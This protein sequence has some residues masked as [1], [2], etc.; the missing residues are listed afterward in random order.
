MRHP[1]RL[2][3]YADR[4]VALDTPSSTL[5]LALAAYAL[6]SVVAVTAY[7]MDKRRAGTGAWRIS[8]A[9]LHGIELLGGWPG[10]LVAQRVFRHKWRKG[11]YMLV[12]WLIVALHVVGW[13]WWSGMLG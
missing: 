13:V 11:S 2:V 3:R 10:A 4:R 9:T 7:W 1:A 5:L 12:F 8:E 6:M